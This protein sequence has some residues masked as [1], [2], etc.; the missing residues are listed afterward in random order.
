MLET[1]DLA[2]RYPGGE[3]L[4][5]PNLRCAPGATHLLLGKS[6][7]G[8]TTL[9]QLLAGLRSPSH[10]KVVVNG[11]E[12]GKLSTAALDQF[13]G[14][15]IGMVFQTAHFVR[16]VNVEENLVLAQRLAGKTTDRRR[17]RELLDVLGLGEKLRSLPA[18]LS[19]GQQQRAAIARAVINQPA[20]MLAD[21]PTSA[22]DDDN[23]SQVL[24]LLQQ[25]AAAVNAT[26]IIVTHDN[27]LTGIIDQRT[28][29]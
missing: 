4:T 17:I 10:G 19:V 5:F 27:R 16:S 22:L 29:L 28:H 8:K 21:E 9:L 11:T 24:G 20:L 6:G 15:N 7:S 13:R 25:Q 14:Q 12:L 1:T 26:L 2:Y 3:S 18:R 23:A